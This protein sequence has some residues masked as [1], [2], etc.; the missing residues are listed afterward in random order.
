MASEDTCLIGEKITVRG[1][2]SGKQNLVVEGRVEGNVTLDSPLTVEPS[3]VVEAD[4]QVTLATVKGRIRGQ[5]Q[6]SR[7]VVLL[8]SCQVTGKVKSPQIVIE[9]GARFSGEIEMDVELP[10]GVQ[11]STT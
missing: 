4:V 6:A 9:E 2:I 11:V 5:L 10:P 1:H 8:A 7:Q 3:G